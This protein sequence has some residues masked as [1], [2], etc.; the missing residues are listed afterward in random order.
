MGGASWEC[1]PSEFLWADQGIG[2]IDEQGDRNDPAQYIVED[3]GSGPSQF[4]A[5][6]R[7]EHASPE[8][9]SANHEEGDVEH[10][11]SP[12]YGITAYNTEAIRPAIEPSLAA[13]CD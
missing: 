12:G 3:H 4:V 8:E 5:G 9:E 7:V 1:P 10:G 6:E 13:R 11:I 2:E